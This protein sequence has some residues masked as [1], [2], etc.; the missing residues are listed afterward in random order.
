MNKR[1]YVSLA[2]VTL[3]VSSCTKEWAER[4][5]H[6]NADNLSTLSAQLF[7]ASAGGSVNSMFH[8]LRVDAFAKADAEGKKSLDFA[9]IVETVPGEYTVGNYGTVKTGKKSVYD[10]TA[11]W[12]MTLKSGII[13]TIK[14]G[15]GFWEVTQAGADAEIYYNI[16]I[17]GLTSTTTIALDA[18]EGG[19]PTFTLVC[20]GIYDEGNGYKTSFE[21]DGELHTEWS[22][23]SYTGAASYTV[24]Y[25]VVY[26]GRTD[27]KFYKGGDCLDWATLIWDN[28]ISHTETSQ[29]NLDNDNY[30]YE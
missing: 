25:N 28:G 3:L 6:R 15:D 30:Y 2:I 10:E 1:I 26:T 24:N 17:T 19:L 16:K 4:G 14:G 5:T 20:K 7:S 23:K 22:C 27:F 11:S 18:I 21:T 29:G 9:G 12:E 8:A 13:Y